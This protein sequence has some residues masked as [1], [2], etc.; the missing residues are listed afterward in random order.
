M[1]ATS[2]ADVAAAVAAFLANGGKVTQCATGDNAL[3]E[4]HYRDPS[5][6]EC[7]CGCHGDWT[8]HT[9]RAGESGRFV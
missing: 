6:A 9:M 4:S 3:R 5:I 2:K 1:Q 8:E 7:L